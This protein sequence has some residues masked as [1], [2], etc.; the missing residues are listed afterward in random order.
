MRTT[1]NSQENDMKEQ[2]DIHFMKGYSSLEKKKQTN[3]SIQFS[4]VYIENFD[5]PLNEP[6]DG[7]FE[8][9]NLQ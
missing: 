6:T 3:K 4:H 2:Q 5:N 8:L 9:A 7:G 1:K